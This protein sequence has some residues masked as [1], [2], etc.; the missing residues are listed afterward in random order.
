MTQKMTNQEKIANKNILKLQP[1]ITPKTL[2]SLYRISDKTANTILETREAIGKILSGEDTR[3]MAIIGPCSIHDPAQALEYAR[4]LKALRAKIEDKILVVMRVYFEKPRTTVGWK[5]LIN[6]PH[7]DDTFELEEGLNTARKLMI[8]I[9]EMGMPIGTEALDPFTPQYLSDLV[10][11][12]AIGARTTESQTHREMASSLSSPVGFKNGT[13]GGLT[14][15]MNA[16]VSA[17]SAHSFLSIN[18]EG[19]SSIV[20][21]TGNPHAHLI[22]R[23][24]ARGPNYDYASIQLAE[25]ELMKNNL[26]LS[27]VVDCSH[28]NS[29]KDFKNQKLVMQAIT[30]QKKDGNKSIKGIMLESHLREGKQKL[31]M[32]KKEELAYGVSITDGCI[33]WEETEE[34]LL[35]FARQL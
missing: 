11:W 17:S 32:G 16:M 3:L 33:G 27:I 14:I 24:G 29:N 34:I 18:E 19:R 13:D 30:L 22:L 1:I 21:S 7:L 8:D 28:D 23:G 25:Q 9:N 5:G 35:D 4:R 31:E 12:S 6:D 20:K 2:K 10:S 15:A 26:P